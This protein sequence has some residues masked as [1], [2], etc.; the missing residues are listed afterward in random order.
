M[1][2]GQDWE[3]AFEGSRYR[4]SV[5]SGA[6]YPLMGTVEHHSRCE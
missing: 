6:C 5:D 4:W 1:R 3:A 2:E